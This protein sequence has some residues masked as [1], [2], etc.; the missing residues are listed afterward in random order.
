MMDQPQINTDRFTPFMKSPSVEVVNKKRNISA[1]AKHLK[2]GN[3]I[4]DRSISTLLPSTNSSMYLTVKPSQMNQY[5]QLSKSNMQSSSAFKAHRSSQDTYAELARVPNKVF[6][7]LARSSRNHI[8]D[9]KSPKIH[10]NVKLNLR[11]TLQGK[12]KI[13]LRSSSII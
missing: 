5:G 7:S 10:S 4:Q 12:R 2:Q 8:K 1:K 11:T 9:S 6:Q 3:T 13:E